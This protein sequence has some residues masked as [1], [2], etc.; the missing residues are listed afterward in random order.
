MKKS[1]LFGFL[2]LCLWACNSA[3]TSNESSEKADSS[4]GTK[5]ET[6]APAADIEYAYMPNGHA[7]DYWEMGDPKNTATV[8]AGLKAYES[9]NIDECV[10]AFGDSVMLYFDGFAAKLSHDSLTGFL[11]KGRNEYKNIV[12]KMDDYLTVTSKDK[13]ENWVSLWYKEISTDLKGKT[14]SIECFDDLK[15]ENGKIVLLSQK[16][17]HYPK[18]KA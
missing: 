17:R 5:P 14:D 10:T 4:T 1:F 16:I 2:L 3:G 6:A 13:K 18:K 8:L 15:L 9:N 7:P 11:K 12:V